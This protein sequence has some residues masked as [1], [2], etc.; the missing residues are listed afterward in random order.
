M[1]IL[2]QFLRKWTLGPSIFW[3]L[4][5]IRNGNF[6]KVDQ[7]VHQNE[8]LYTHLC[9]SPI[10]CPSHCEDV[11]GHFVLFFAITY[12]FCEV[13]TDGCPKLP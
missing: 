12:L 2:A 4:P 1:F 7:K 5:L 10:L 11:A 8:H 13:T 3:N 9:E 6:R